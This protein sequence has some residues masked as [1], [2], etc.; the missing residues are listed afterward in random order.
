MANKPI[1]FVFG[2]TGGN[3]QTPFHVTARESAHDKYF[4][5]VVSDPTGAGTGTGTCT[6]TNPGNET[7]Y[8]TDN[9][10]DP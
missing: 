2:K 6:E 8:D 9:D 5:S 10:S 3:N 7:N 1:V 4:V